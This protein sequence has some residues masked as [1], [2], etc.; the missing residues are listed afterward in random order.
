MH[1]NAI[2]NFFEVKSMSL[3]ISGQVLGMLLFML[4][5]WTLSY[6]S[7]V[8]KQDKEHMEN[9]KWKRGYRKRGE[10]AMSASAYKTRSAVLSFGGY[11]ISMAGIVTFI[12]TTPWSTL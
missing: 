11:G 3:P 5:L 6:C 1:L 10:K 4:G 2:T 12:M 9:L 8:E 7:K